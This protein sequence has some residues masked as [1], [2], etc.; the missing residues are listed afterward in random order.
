M[1]KI[2]AKQLFYTR[3]E[4]D[5]SPVNEPGYQ[6]VYQSS[7]IPS[8]LVPK[9]EERINCFSE[10]KTSFNGKYIYFVSDNHAILCHSVPI[11]AN[12]I[13]SDTV[14]RNVVF[15]A[16]VLIIN[17]SDFQL[18]NNNP[19]IIFEL[20]NLFKKDISEIVDAF[21]P[22]SGVA[23]SKI[24]EIPDTQITV[25][26]DIPYSQI[27][28]SIALSF[29]AKQK[30]EHNQ[31]VYLQ[32]TQHEIWKHLYNLFIYLPPSARLN[33][34]FDS[35]ITGCSVPEKSFMFLGS[36]VRPNKRFFAQINC[37]TLSFSSE[38]TIATN[39][40]YLN[41]LFSNSSSQI[42]DAE[43]VQDAQLIFDAILANDVKIFSDISEPTASA[44]FQANKTDFS[45]FL[46]E[47]LSGKLDAEWADLLLPYVFQKYDKSSLLSIRAQNEFDYD[48]LTHVIID[49]LRDIQTLP[50]DKHLKNLVDLGQK[51][52]NNVLIHWGATLVK[53]P[54]V[55]LRNEALDSMSDEEFE[56]AISKLL[57]PLP[58]EHFVSQGKT[59]ILFENLE[60]SLLANEY[61]Y[62]LVDALITSN[63]ADE[64][65][66]I[67]PELDRLDRST[68]KKIWK[69]TQKNQLPTTFSHAVEKKFSDSNSFK[70][71]IASLFKS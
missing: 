25:A 52:D 39:N 21:G 17:L 40:Y 10:L 32:G 7:G 16:H 12:P 20:K 70:S 64:L 46:Y 1:V 8:S 58:P 44:F 45:S 66:K 18:I 69:A 41:W 63:L 53:N 2:H 28:N 9:I 23:P 60:L 34:P 4:A 26:P 43:D 54:Q 36:N 67:V 48:S 24:I 37:N 31:S 35:F 29:L 11:E 19:F 68:I 3:V 47:A 61:F 50:D 27:K 6:I 13:I 51:T 56:I 38:E 65:D 57:K 49:Y 30:I 71:R 59:A 42:L 62:P 33:C 55:E 14:R 22:A 15:I 5:Y